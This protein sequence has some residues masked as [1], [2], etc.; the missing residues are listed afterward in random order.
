MKA[1]VLRSYHGG[2]VLLAAL[3]LIASHAVSAHE[4]FIPH[5]PTAPLHEAF[6]QSLNPD[7][8]TI[9]LRGALLMAILLALWLLRQPLNDFVEHRLLRH[10]PSR[11]RK[12]L[13]LVARFLMD[14]PVEHP[15]F[16][17][18]VSG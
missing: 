3:L 1:R 5:T 10:L 8:L 18:V 4:R 15:W 14:Q 13:R 11:P 6:F 9:G 16:K 7:M 12:L 17:A 2:A